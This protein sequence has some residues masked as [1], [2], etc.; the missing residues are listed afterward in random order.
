MHKPDQNDTIRHHGERLATIE[1]WRKSVDD[2]NLDKRIRIL[3]LWKNTII[4]IVVFVGWMFTTVGK[5]FI[6][7]I[8]GL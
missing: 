3:E 5:Q 2:G 7:F 8:G 6:E 4:G 1:A